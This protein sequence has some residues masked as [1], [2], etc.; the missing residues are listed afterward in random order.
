M[1]NILFLFSPYQ[2]NYHNRFGIDILKK[3]FEVKIFDCTPWMNR[4]YWDLYSKNS[5]KNNEHIVVNNKN[6]FLHHIT[7]I[8]NAYIIENLPNNSN[9]NWIRKILKEKNCVFVSRNLNPIPELQKN[10]LQ[11]INTLFK[12]FLNIKKTFYMFNQFIQK[13]Q[14]NI[15]KSD[16]EIFIAGGLAALKKIKKNNII[17]AHSM[18]YDVYL[19]T[20]DIKSN[21]NSKKYAVFLDQDMANHPDPIVLGIER[22]VDELK[23]YEVLTKFLKNFEKNSKLKVII[24]IHPKSRNKNLQNLLHGIE[25]SKEN[26]ATL[27]KN[28]SLTLLHDSTAISFAILFNK[29]TLFLTSNHLNKTQFGPRIKN[30]AKI[31]NSRII[32]MDNFLEKKISTE[33]MFQFDQSRY[34]DY[35]DQYLKIPNSPNLPIWEILSK[36]IKEKEF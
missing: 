22:E 4:R 9:S 34:K 32:N 17:K 24:S 31:V 6:D 28:S 29:P 16:C 11:K 23:Y 19:K 10:I 36:Q 3:N 1:K 21:E 14:N 5:K 33:G 12:L 35:L 13:K 8:N 18:D 26:S 7:Q 30:V 15:I 25:F 27:V 20:K 2:E